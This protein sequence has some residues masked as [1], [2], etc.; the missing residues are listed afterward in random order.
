M[1]APSSKPL[2]TL[3]E[4]DAR[5][6]SLPTPQDTYLNPLSKLPTAADVVDEKTINRPSAA[7][8]SS[9]SSSTSAKAPAS[10]KKS[11][12]AD[13]SAVGQKGAGKQ[14]EQ[15]GSTLNTSS[16]SSS[17]ED[18]SLKTSREEGEKQDGSRQ[19]PA[20]GAVSGSETDQS[21]AIDLC[22]L[23]D[24]QAQLLPPSWAAA[25]TFEK[26]SN[27]LFFEGIGAD[28]ELDIE[29]SDE[30][31][32]LGASGE[33]AEEFTFGRRKIDLGNSVAKRKKKKG[34]LEIAVALTSS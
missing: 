6:K 21:A 2:P 19:P 15:A 28:T 3:E 1:P 29:I 22:A 18:A 13:A 33:D 4:F 20:P 9:A 31:I 25:V 30:L 34:T 16:S 24:P 26:A 23:T 14:Q 32:R 10:A 11:K 17:A 8:N 27:R 7:K 5:A 12:Q